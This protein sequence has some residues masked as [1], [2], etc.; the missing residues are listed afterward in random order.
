VADGV[1]ENDGRRCRAFLRTREEKAEIN[2]E[3]D[4]NKTSGMIHHNEK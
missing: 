1:V 4:G 3:K 2:D